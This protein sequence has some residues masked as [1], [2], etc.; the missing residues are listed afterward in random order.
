VEK[1]PTGIASVMA[2]EGAPVQ[3][4]RLLPLWGMRICIT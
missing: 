2:S 3:P 1:K 4:Q